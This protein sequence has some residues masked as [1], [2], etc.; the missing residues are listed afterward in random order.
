[1]KVLFLSTYDIEGGAARATIWLAKGLRKLG[2]NLKMVVQNKLG[3]DYW[4]IGP[5]SKV[6]KALGVMRPT[7]DTI[8]L[9]FYPNKNRSQWSFNLLPNY[10]LS[11][12]ISNVCPDIINIHWVG[13]GFL[14]ISYL[15]KINAPIVW[16]LYD[17]WPFTGG[18]HY[19]NF[20]GNYISSCSNCPQLN[21]SNYDIS[22]FIL[23]TKSKAW[24]KVNM[25]I[26]APSKW[27]AEEAK[28]SSLFSNYRIEVIPHGTDI[29]F[30]KPIDKKISRNILGIPEDG[31]Y[32]L[33]GA[34]GGNSDTRKGYQL[35]EQALK[36]LAL[37]NDLTNLNLLIFGSSQPEAFPDLGFPVFYLGR[38]RDDVSLAVLYS[39]AD[40]TITP[41]MQEAF[42]MSASESFACGTPVVAFAATGV[43]DVVDHMKNG[44][45]A[46]PYDADDLSKGISWMLSD[47]ERLKNISV[48]AREK[49][50]NKFSLEI[51]SKQYQDLYF[52]LLL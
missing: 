16:S 38:L 35:L 4:V 31:Q 29:N 8:L 34:M 1:M 44:Y 42:G 20:C 37:N 5:D 33:F 39:A 52:E 18:C 11:K 10:G 43:L 41:S 23:K 51:V 7:I 6:N 9:K 2:I 21:N 46:K 25:T 45:L 27:L 40:I 32:I 24:D 48:N 36:K 17:M 30:F 47:T 50:I 49:C 22:R 13:G 28:K 12:S 19:D 3:D 15:E 26:V 14:P